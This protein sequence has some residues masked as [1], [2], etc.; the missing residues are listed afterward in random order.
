MELKHFTE[1]AA[2]ND[3]GIITPFQIRFFLVMPQLGFTF[4]SHPVGN[5]GHNEG[6]DPQSTIKIINISNRCQV[7]YLSLK[8]C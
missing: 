7:R 3:C 1:N 8:P 4:V 2:N 5:Q 6:L